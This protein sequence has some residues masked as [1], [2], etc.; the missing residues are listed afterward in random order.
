MMITLDERPWSAHVHRSQVKRSDP[1]QPPGRM[2]HGR[3]AGLSFVAIPFYIAADMALN[4]SAPVYLISI[5]VV[6][7]IDHLR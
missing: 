1:G 6:P 5:R 7:N 2:A 3:R 4:L